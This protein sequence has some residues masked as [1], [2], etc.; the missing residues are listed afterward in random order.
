MGA[1]LTGHLQDD[2]GQGQGRSLLEGSVIPPQGAEVDRDEAR[3]RMCGLWTSPTPGASSI[4]SCYSPFGYEAP[5][6]WPSSG[7]VIHSWQDARFKGVPSLLNW[8]FK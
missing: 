3:E 1:T 6:S 7:V 5:N 2:Q 4:G 8:V